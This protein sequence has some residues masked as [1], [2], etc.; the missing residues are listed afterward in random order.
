MTRHEFRSPGDACEETPTVDA[1]SP[2]PIS[3]TPQQ[4][5]SALGWGLA[6]AG[7]AL[8]WVVIAALFR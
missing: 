2:L 1:A 8:G 5:V 3:Q 6:L 7:G 4:P